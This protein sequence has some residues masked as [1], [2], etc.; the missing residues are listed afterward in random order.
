MTLTVNQDMSR[1]G[2]GGVLDG[3]L[4][5]PARG[6]LGQSP[7]LI[8]AQVGDQQLLSMHVDFMRM[9]AL[10]AFRVWTGSVELDICSFSFLCSCID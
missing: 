8:R 10:L 4:H 9:G 3:S 5:L 2:P 7:S 6:T 1:P